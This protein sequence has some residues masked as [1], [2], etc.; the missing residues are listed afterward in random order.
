MASLVGK[1]VLNPLVTAP[2]LLLLTGPEQ[3]REPLLQQ[4]RQLVSSDAISKAVTTL[5]WLTALGRSLY[6]QCQRRDI[7]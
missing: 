2:L 4:L 6:D 7:C 3:V 5:R 1:V